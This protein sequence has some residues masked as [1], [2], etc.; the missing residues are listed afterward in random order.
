[1]RIA[2]RILKAAYVEKRASRQGSLHRVQALWIRLRLLASVENTQITRLAERYGA[3]RS[4]QIRHSA[5]SSR[6]LG[7]TLGGRP[8]RPWQYLYL[9]PDPHGQRSLR[10]TFGVL[11][12]RCA[13]S[14][15][16]RSTRCA[17]V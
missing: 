11:S 12:P 16:A 7:T 14:F 6:Y 5:L 9:S 3:S 17:S 15:D 2:S 1:M 8:V 4:E 13:A 10:P